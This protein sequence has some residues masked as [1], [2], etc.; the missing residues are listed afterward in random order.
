MTSLHTIG[1]C[2]E[3]GMYSMLFGMISVLSTLTKRVLA[4]WCMRARGSDGTKQFQRNSIIRRGLSKGLSLPLVYIAIC[5]IA[6]IANP[7]GRRLYSY[8]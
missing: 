4:D 1:I 3:Y 8:N 7:L 2:R 6:T 5:V